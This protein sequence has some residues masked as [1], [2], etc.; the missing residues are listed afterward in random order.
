M[1]ASYLLRRTL[2]FNSQGL[3]KFFPGIAAALTVDPEAYLRD[4]LTKGFF[5][6]PD[7]RRFIEILRQEEVGYYN[8]EIVKYLLY[9]LEKSVNKEVPALEKLQLEHIMP[10]TLDEDWKDNLG[11][12]WERIHR[13]FVNKLGNLT[14]TGY[15]QELQNFSFAK[16]KSNKNGYSNSSLKITRE[17][18]SYNNWGEQEITKRGEEL[19][20]RIAGMWVI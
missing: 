14:L 13:E 17:L 4:T 19:S 16:K 20:A 12:E 18:A 3:N 15:N 7:N 9:R 10:Q 5:A 11:P 6:A 1:V 2:A 8:V